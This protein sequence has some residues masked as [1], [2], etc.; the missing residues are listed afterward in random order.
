LTDTLKRLVGPTALTN[1]AADQYTVPA[2]TTTTVRSIHVCNET[3]AQHD[4]TISIGADAAGKRLF[5]NQKVDA[6][7]SFDWSGNIVLA[8][9]EKIQALADANTAIT[10]TVSGIETA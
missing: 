4:F 3:A 5:K 6:N 1:A 7:D 8:A 2:A 10:L 9:A